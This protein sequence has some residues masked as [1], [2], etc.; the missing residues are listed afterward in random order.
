[1]ARAWGA[2]LAVVAAAAGVRAEEKPLPQ[3]WDYAAAMKKVAAGSKARPGVV[4]HVGDSITYANPY[5]QWAR[6][7]K[8]QTDDDKAALKW[9]HASAD[10]DTDGWYLARFDHPD[11]GRSYTACGGIRADEM[12]AGGKSKMPPLAK[13]LDQYKPQAVVLMLGTNDASAGRS[14]DDY[15]ADMAKAVDA[16]LDHGAVCIL[17]TIPPHP[18]KS[19][20]AKQYNDA[21]HKLAKDRSLPLIDY[22]QE[23]LTRRQDDWNGTLLGKND[24]H[25]TA[26]QGGA[27]AASEPTAE[28]LRNSGYLL[29]GWL[30]V[31]K[32]AEVKKAVFDD[33]GK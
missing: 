32:I 30:S 18:G 12:L 4:L 19:D 24:V 11:G 31:K 16:I 13:L 2:V 20:L 33:A 29:R 23:V 26:S 10:D 3:A 27:T 22:E 9:M 5:G 21:L 7:G 1:M 28:N 25:P 6:S 14:V 15:K 8:G 17:S